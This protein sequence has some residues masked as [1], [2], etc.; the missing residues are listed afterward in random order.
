[1][2]V[3]GGGGRPGNRFHLRRRACASELKLGGGDVCAQSGISW[4]QSPADRQ[5]VLISV[6]PSPRGAADA[7]AGWS[8]SHPQFRG[9]HGIVDIHPLSVMRIAGWPGSLTRATPL[10]RALRKTPDVGR[11]STAASLGQKG[12]EATNRRYGGNRGSDR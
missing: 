12:L 2:V 8:T 11:E 4:L 9:V 5:P 1:M 6:Q 10:G 3:N 7:H